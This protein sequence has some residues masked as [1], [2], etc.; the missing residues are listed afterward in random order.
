MPQPPQL[1]QD[2]CGLQRNHLHGMLDVLHTYSRMCIQ[3]KFIDID[4]DL[5]ELHIQLSI[6]CHCE[7]SELLSYHIL[8]HTDK[9]SSLSHELLVTYY[10][11]VDTFHFLDSFYHGNI[12]CRM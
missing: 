7:L 1:S 12:P 6:I 11:H 2:I 10:F 9:F 5:R 3:V 8:V 4:N